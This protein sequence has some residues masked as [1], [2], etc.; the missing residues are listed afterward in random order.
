MMGDCCS[1]Q[2]RLTVKESIDC[3]ASSDGAQA[4]TAKVDNNGPDAQFP[5]EDAEGCN[6]GCR[7]DQQKYQN[8]AG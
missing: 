1:D 8:S 4:D 2:K 6:V 5:G 7:A 3:Q